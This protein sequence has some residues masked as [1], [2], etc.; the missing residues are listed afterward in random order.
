VLR[1]SMFLFKVSNEDGP[2]N[3]S[4]QCFFSHVIYRYRSIREDPTET[5]HAPENTANYV[6]GT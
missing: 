5:D 6:L 1:P 3:A 4:K 2:S